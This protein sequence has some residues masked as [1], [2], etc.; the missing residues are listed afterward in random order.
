MK[1]FSASSSIT[2]NFKFKKMNKI[3]VLK[4]N[5]LEL[6]TN[7]Q[8]KI[9][10]VAKDDQSANFIRHY[11][12]SGLTNPVNIEVKQVEI[13]D[14]LKLKGDTNEKQMPY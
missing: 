1:I 14:L 8:E 5:V 11:F 3:K 2:Y 4:N 13:I 10:I 6:H 12:E 7:S 9:K